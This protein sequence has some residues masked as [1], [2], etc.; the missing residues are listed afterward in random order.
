MKILNDIAGLNRRRFS[1]RYGR[2]L[3]FC[4]ITL[5]GALIG[6]SLGAAENNVAVSVPVS[7]PVAKPGEGQAVTAESTVFRSAAEQTSLLELYT[8]QGCYSCPPAEDWLNDLTEYD[9][10]WQKVVPIA[11]HVDY[12][13]YLGW[14]DV[15]ALKDNQ[16]RHYAYKFQ[17]H[18]RGIFT[19][20]MVMNGADW[21]TWRQGE[22]PN[23]ST[24]K[25]PGELEV[26]LSGNRVTVK[27]TRIADSEIASQPLRAHIA[28]L[29]FGIT[30]A[31]PSGE[32]AGKT[33]QHEFVALSRE[34]KSA[35]PVG[36]IYAWTFEHLQSDHSREKT[37][38]AAWVSGTEDNVP[39]QATGGWLGN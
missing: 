26:Q 9:S 36:G 10:L 22:L 25:R 27:F 16:K 23:F 24:E 14:K 35:H 39:L 5:P 7:E 38:I 30:T 1:S 13:D 33:L 4:V 37:A 28:L 34:Q 20:Q 11:L 21:L 19:P 15:Y 17:G 18:T 12:W 32:N 8:S 29:G 3:L 2:L 31:I 6:H